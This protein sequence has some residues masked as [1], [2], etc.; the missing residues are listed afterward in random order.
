MELKFKNNWHT[1]V[2]GSYFIC[3]PFV[4]KFFHPLLY[5]AY[6]PL[7]TSGVGLLILCLGFIEDHRNRQNRLSFTSIDILVVSYLGYGLFHSLLCRVE[8]NIFSFYQWIA[9]GVFYILCRK[10]PTPHRLLYFISMAGFCQALYGLLQWCEWIESPHRLF[11]ITGTFGN[12]SQVG[13]FLCI[14]I[15]I[16]SA[17]LVESLRHRRYKQGLLLTGM[18]VPMIIVLVLSDSRASWIGCCLAFIY[19][20]GTSGLNMKRMFWVGLP[21]VFCLLTL[22]LY[23]YKP[24]SADGRLFIWKVSGT[25]IK[26]QP[27]LGHGIN[28]FA[29]KYMLYQADYFKKHP[30]SRFREIADNVNTPYNEFIHLT[31]EQGITGV[32]LLLLL[33][34]FL[35]LPSQIP[36]QQ[37]FRSGVVAFAVFSFFSYPVNT[38]PLLFL[39][40]LLAGSCRTNSRKAIIVPVTVKWIFLATLIFYGSTELKSFGIYHKSISKLISHTPDSQRYV[41]EQF[42]ILKYYPEIL[43]LELYTNPEM[44]GNDRR[45]LQEQIALLQP[46]TENYGQLGQSYLKAGFY[47]EAEKYFSIA[48]D[49]VPSRMQ[50]NYYLF[51]LYQQTGDT[52]AARR[53]ATK[54]LQQPVKTENTFTLPARGEVRR[55]LEATLFH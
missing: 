2:I 15:V 49:M 35:L 36:E 25:M 55:Y 39:F 14:T 45:R 51:K 23:F 54:I 42:D 53:R 28:S 38:F 1:F 13:G 29:S 37:I 3:F 33:Y 41:R 10:N 34:I 6:M 17:L 24:D 32:V 52:A 40:V 47:K 27:I 20:A 21:V 12:P 7:I 46:N 48:A 18:L 30:A 16:T 43:Q 8:L 5:K 50:A 31:V 9:L 19:L 26:E 22:A 44:E 4:F 11:T